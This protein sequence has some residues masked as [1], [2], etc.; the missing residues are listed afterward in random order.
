[1]SKR[2]VQATVYVDG[3]DGEV[4]VVFE[5]TVWDGEELEV[6][7]A[8]PKHYLDLYDEC[9]A[10]GDGDAFMDLVDQAMWDAYREACEDS[11]GDW[12]ETFSDRAPA[13]GPLDD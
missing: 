3:E 2:T 12:H 13:P 5:G 7:T 6:H 9:A 10:T 11:E 8:T 1:M 4:E